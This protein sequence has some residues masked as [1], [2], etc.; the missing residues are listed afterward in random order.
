MIRIATIMIRNT[1]DACE[2]SDD[3]RTIPK[4]DSKNIHQNLHIECIVLINK[5]HNYFVFFLNKFEAFLSHG[6]GIY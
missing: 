4:N 3:A 2:L 5:S 6:I 1:M